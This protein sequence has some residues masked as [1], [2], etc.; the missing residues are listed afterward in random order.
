MEELN[1]SIEVLSLV[2]D[3]SFTPIEDLQ[4]EED[5][6][7]DWNNFTT[8]HIATRFIELYFSNRET[9][10]LMFQDDMFYFYTGIYWRE[11]PKK[12]THFLKQ[13]FIGDEG[14]YY[15]CLKALKFIKETIEERIFKELTKTI[16]K[17]ETNS[18]RNEII[19]AVK[20]LVFVN[21][22][23][24][25]NKHN[26]LF[27]F[28][29]IILNVNTGKPEPANP[30]LYINI[31]CGYNYFDMEKYDPSILV[32]ARKEITDF[33]YSLVE[34][35][36][37]EVFLWKFLSSFLYGGNPFEKAYFLLGRGRNG[38]GTLMTLLSK[39]MGNYYGELNLEYYTQPVRAGANEN[40]Y[41]IRNARLINTAEAESE[42][43]NYTSQ[44][45]LLTNFKKLTGGDTIS[46]AGKYKSEVHFKAGKPIIQTNEMPVFKVRRG[47]DSILSLTERIE[48]ITFPFSFITDEEEIARTPDKCRK[49]DNTIKQKFQNDPLYIYA[50][51]SLMLEKIQDERF[52]SSVMGGKFITEESPLKVKDAK[53]KYFTN[54]KDNA[55][56]IGDF[57]DEKIDPTPTGNDKDVIDIRILYNEYLENYDKNS[58]YK[59]FTE[60]AI[61]KYGTRSL[62]KKGAGVY[63][64]QNEHYIQGYKFKAIYPER[65]EQKLEEKFNEVNRTD[66]PEAKQTI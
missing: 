22:F 14:F 33:V 13:Y 12:D 19:D 66:I 43:D 64:N 35:E 48:I 20:T 24:D 46:V 45:F 47:D 55:D 16:K 31:T 23:I 4:A 37:M 50:M 56:Y 53:E 27:T 34:D 54:L 5:A 52:R 1:K 18:G 57:F 6:K 9:K 59:H 7:I 3:F 60:T 2:R 10:T 28:N 40:L 32:G 21:T 36:E 62:T 8:N 11:I 51:I 65:V 15:H 38:K 63:R 29:D 42:A 41:N 25:W 30:A 61:K 58:K 44:V 26:H 17:M 39:V 49:R